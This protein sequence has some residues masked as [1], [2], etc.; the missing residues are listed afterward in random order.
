M[1][2]LLRYLHHLCSIV[3]GK[4]SLKFNLLVFYKPFCLWKLSLLC[5]GA[6]SY[7]YITAF[8]NRITLHISIFQTKNILKHKRGRTKGCFVWG[9]RLMSQ[10]KDVMQPPDTVSWFPLYSLRHNGKFKIYHL[11]QCYNILSIW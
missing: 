1:H 10:L 2:L 5:W 3:W 8:H 4:K 11:P 7:F 9:N 6:R